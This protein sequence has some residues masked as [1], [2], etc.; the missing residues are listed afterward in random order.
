MTVTSSNLKQEKSSRGICVIMAGGRGTRFWPLSRTHMPKQLLPL[1]GDNSLLRETYERLEPLVGADRILVITSGSLA[2]PTRAQ[3]PEL[4]PENII[5]EPVGRNTAPCAVLGMAVA[6]KIDPSAPVALLPADH[7]IPDQ[8]VFRN[9]LSQA[10]ELV[11]HKKTVVTFGIRPNRPETGYGYIETEDLVDSAGFRSGLRFVE[12]PDLQTAAEYLTSGRFFWNSGIFIWNPDFFATS[13]REFVP[14]ICDLMAPVAGTFGTDGFSQALDIAYDNCPADSI[15][16]AVMEKLPGFTLTEAR[17]TWS[18][19][20]SWD[21]WGELAPSMGDGNRG[22]G[23]ILA[24]DSANNILMGGE[25]RT[26]AMVG[27]EDLIVVDT[28][29]ALLI[30]RKADAQRIKEVISH[31]EKD[32]RKDLL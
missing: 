17:F 27:V 9:Q 6:A 30:C 5:T 11:S 32:G 22:K 3:L 31:L 12:K 19:L 14:V 4:P 28:P 29:D 13:S 1:G 16:Y 15:D 24:V 8:D 21:S 7:F 26:I 2:E 25:G 18:D 20:G 23:Q 10:F